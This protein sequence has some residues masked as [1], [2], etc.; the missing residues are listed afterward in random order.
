MRYLSHFEA[1][2]LPSTDEGLKAMNDIGAA[3]RA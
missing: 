3:L 2:F 1:A